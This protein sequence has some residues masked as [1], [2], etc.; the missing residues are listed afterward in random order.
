MTIVQVSLLEWLSIPAGR[1]TLEGTSDY[2]DIAPFRIA[3]YPI[4]NAQFDTFI[5]DDGYKH[6]IWWDG[7]A[8]H[9][10]SPRPS[11]WRDPDAPKLEICWFEA[12]AFTRWLSDQTELDV[13]LP[14]E[15]EWQWAAVGDS[16]W[17]YAYGSEF[18]PS[19]CN[20]KESGIERTNRV[21]AYDGVTTHSGAVDMC[22]N[23]WEWCLNEAADPYKV[24]IRGGE[25]RALRGG[26]WND[27]ANKA[28]ATSRSNRSPRTRTF[29]IGFRVIATP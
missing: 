18:D 3:K 26:S 4:T 13:R 17:A 28:R 5:Q 19:K 14:T 22:G 1:I 10:T 20:T 9:V 24:S 6:P 29:N 23:V 8:H 27:A 12:V 25:N 7:L 15:W 21:T 16:G 2:F 11:D